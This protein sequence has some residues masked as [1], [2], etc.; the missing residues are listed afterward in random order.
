MEYL[1]YRPSPSLEPLINIYWSL[2]V[3]KQEGH[4]KQRIIPDGCIEMA[5]ILGEDIKRYTS[6]DNFII[7]PRAMVIG[8]IVD[9]F[10]IEPVGEVD[11]FSIS[12]FP[13]GFSNLINQSLDDLVNKETPLD[14]LFD[15]K[16][17][18]LL[19]NNI[20]HAGSTQERIDIVE[21]FLLERLQEN[22]VIDQVIKT[23]VDAIYQS[24]GNVKIVDIFGKDKGSRRRLER[25]FKKHIGLSPKQLGKVMRLQAALSLLLD[26]EPQ[27][28]TKIAYSS[29]YYDQS[30]FIKDFKEFTGV[31]PKDFL[32]SDEMLLSSE[33]YK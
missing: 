19:E 30:H 3:S 2:K 23:T 33:F 9:P 1:T 11:T 8:Q 13:L 27:S 25:Q 7:Q 14:E 20:I 28:L 5:F 21:T 16:I 4:S 26:K 32:G 15:P 31:T 17:I 12:F 6:D 24:R 29:E 22:K 10:Y 18:R